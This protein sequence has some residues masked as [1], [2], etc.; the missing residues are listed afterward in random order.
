LSSQICWP[1]ARAAWIGFMEAG[2]GVTVS[3]ND[4]AILAES[5]GR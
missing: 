1:A 2:F 5:V 4:V 3:G